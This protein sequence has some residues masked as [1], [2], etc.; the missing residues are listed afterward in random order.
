MQCGQDTMIWIKRNVP[1]EDLGTVGK[2]MNIRSLFKFIEDERISVPT[3]K[4][5]PLFHRRSAVVNI[6]AT[7]LFNQLF[8]V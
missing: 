8:H 6:V 3:K 2:I 5:S 1:F 7:Q 4:A